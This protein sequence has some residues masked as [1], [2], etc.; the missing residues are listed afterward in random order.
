MT[1]DLKSDKGF[2]RRSRKL[3]RRSSRRWEQQTRKEEQLWSVLQGSAARCPES[4]VH[5]D[6]IILLNAQFQKVTSSHRARTAT[7]V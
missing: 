1:V 5:Q 4:T 6:A 2:Q 7:I 3:S